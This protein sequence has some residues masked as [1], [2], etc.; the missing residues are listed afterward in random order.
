M[1]YPLSQKYAEV[2]GDSSNKEARLK[3]GS[4]LRQ[5]WMLGFG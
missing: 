3:H 1:M 5:H 2:I 4:M